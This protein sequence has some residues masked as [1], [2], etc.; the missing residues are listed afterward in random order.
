M[1]IQQ[2]ISNHPQNLLARKATLVSSDYRPID[3]QIVVRYYIEYVDNEGNILPGPGITGY[4]KTFVI[5]K[6]HFVDANGNVVETGG[7]MSEYDFYINAIDNGYNYFQLHESA[8]QLL[9]QNGRF[10]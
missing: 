6:N 9:D 4:E 3:Q 10:N 2:T 8:I 7:I 1:V 5:D